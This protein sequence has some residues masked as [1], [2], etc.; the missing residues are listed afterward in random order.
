LKPSNVILNVKMMNVL[1]NYS[2][3]LLLNAERRI[4]LELQNELKLMLLNGYIHLV[5]IY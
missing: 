5:S 2:K 3:E 1:D 4:C